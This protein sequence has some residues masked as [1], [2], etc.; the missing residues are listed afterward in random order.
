MILNLLVK[1]GQKVCKVKTEQCDAINSPLGD[2]LFPSDYGDCE[3]FIIP[4]LETSLYYDRYYHRLN[5]T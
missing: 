3:T 4:V 5:I 2:K 1:E